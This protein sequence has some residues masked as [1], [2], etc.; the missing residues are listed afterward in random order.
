MNIAAER[1]RQAFFVRQE[2]RRVRSRRRQQC[3]EYHMAT[4]AAAQRQG[5]LR[6][7]YGLGGGNEH[8]HGIVIQ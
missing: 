1:R 5:T 7:N 3:R 4:L 6:R 2:E 8:I